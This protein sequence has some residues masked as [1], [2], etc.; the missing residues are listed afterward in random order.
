MVVP[1]SHPESSNIFHAGVIIMG[2]PMSAPQQHRLWQTTQWGVFLLALSVCLNYID[3]GTLAIAGPVVIKELGLSASQFG[4]LNSAFFITYAGLMIPAGWLVDRY[5]VKWILAGGF[6][7]WSLATGLTGMATGFASL[8]FFRLLLGIGESVAYP[9]YSKIIT[10]YFPP[11]QRGLPNAFIDA[12]SKMG[13]ALGILFGGLLVDSYGWRPFFVV[14]GLGGLI[15]LVPWML[16]RT[17]QASD[18]TPARIGGSVGFG[19]I[20]R[21]REAWGLMFGHFSFNYTWY[22]LISWLPYY[23]VNERHY[24]QREM[25][26][27]GSLPFW[28]IAISSLTTGWLSDRW[29]AKGRSATF[30]RKAFLCTGLL[31]AAALLPFASILEPDASLRLVMVA[32][33]GLGFCSSNLWAVT[34]TLAGIPAAGKWSGL[35]NGFGNLGGVV[36]PMLTGFVVDA[37]GSFHLPF[38]ACSFVLVMGALSFLF[39]IPRVEP[40]NWTL[41]GRRP[42]TARRDAGG[43]SL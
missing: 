21:R 35:Q 7:L 31:S 40:I 39:L 29:I 32:G 17:R 11:E 33:F 9:A 5:N 18:D 37:T 6:F 23:L 4:I 3:R 42:A 19:D 8:L 28:V 1:R 25:A 16:W 22:F 24:S 38:V 12:F 36:S 43:Y 27:F 26:T 30:V 41:R 2:E 15:W 13:P 10:R 20:L 34:Q 14:A